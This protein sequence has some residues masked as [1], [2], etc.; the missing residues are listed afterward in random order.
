MAL[1]ADCPL[2]ALADRR[3][4]A[5][6]ALW[7]VVSGLV[8]GLVTAIIPN[9]VFGRSV[10]PEPFAIWT[11]LVSAPLMGLVLATYTA[12][13]PASPIVMLTALTPVEEERV[14]RRSSTLGSLAGFGTF[15]AIGCPVCNKVA[16]LLLGASGALSVWAPIQPWV[17]AASL[18][19]L[20]VTVIW[21]LRLR[22]SGGACA[23]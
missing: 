14:E 7:T 1:P 9:P 21:R 17:A 8:Y 23:I 12:R 3:L 11:W 10:A 15:L 18:V 13:R 2:L 6:T 4:L 19:M 20:V 22:V 16:L 5:W